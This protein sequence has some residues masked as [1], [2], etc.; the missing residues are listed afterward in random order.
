MFKQ[1]PCCPSITFPPLSALLI[2]LAGN[3]LA[4][5]LKLVVGN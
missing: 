5:L 1:P 4:Y 2:I 3:R